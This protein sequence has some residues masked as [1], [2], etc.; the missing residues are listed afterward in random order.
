MAPREESLSAD[1]RR[2]ERRVAWL[3]FGFLSCVY[4]LSGKGFSEILDAEG[5]YLITKAIV[6]DGEVGVKTELSS[7]VLRGDEPT[8]DGRAFLHFGIGYPL[9]MVPFYV[10]GKVAGQV[11]M[12]ADP[13]FQR[14]ERFYTRASTS[15]AMAFVTALT[16]VGVYYLLLRLGLLILPSAAGGLL[17]GLATYAWPYAKIGFYEPF[18]GLCQVLALLWAMVY[19]TTH[20]AR[21]LVLAGFAVGWG[22]AAKPS[23]GLLLPVIVGYVAWAAWTGDRRG[24]EARVLVAGPALALG[25]ALWVGVMLWYNAERTGV[26]T[27]PGYNPGN[28]TPT[29]D[30]VHILTALFGNAFSTGRGFFIY[31]PVALLFLLGLPWMWRR[32]RGELVAILSLIALNVLFF[33]MRGNWMTMRPWGPRYLVPLS[34]LFIIIAMPGIVAVWHRVSARRLIGCLIAVSVCVQL[35]A[36]AMPFGTWLDR[37]KEET[38]TSASAVYQLKYWPIWGQ[39]V[40]LSDARLSPIDTAGANIATGEP[41]EEFKREIRLTPDFWS[42]YMYRLG[43]P[44]WL[45]LLGVIVPAGL[46]ALLGVLLGRAMRQCEAAVR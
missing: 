42:A 21:W 44:A 5:Y 27:N 11:A 12:A 8:R 3:L 14:F 38:G 25:A 20:R 36:I 45:V 7:A 23:L 29:L 32:A 39:V 13:R 41:P 19:K 9:A 33:A 4:L 26:A 28:Y 22:I 17:F 15:A 31:S 6:E 10:V 30:M 24:R 43:V 2:R 35:L 46:T 40:L 18:L 34:A 1:R 37:V 16:G